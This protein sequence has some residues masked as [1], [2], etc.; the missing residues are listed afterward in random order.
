MLYAANP[1]NLVIVYWRSDQ[2][3][4]MASIYLPLMLLFLLRVGE[5]GRR[6]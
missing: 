1:Y 4:L 3:E 2:A 5:D 6:D